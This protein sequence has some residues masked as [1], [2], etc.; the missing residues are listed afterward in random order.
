MA[1]GAGADAAIS[2]TPLSDP[3]PR[4]GSA[5]LVSFG[6]GG[7]WQA[8][9]GFRL[10]LAEP[11]AG[12]GDA[13]PHWDPANRLLT[14]F[15]PKGSLFTLPLTSFLEPDDLALMGQWQWLRQFIERI[16]VTSPRPEILQPGGLMDR[17]AHVLQRGVEGGHWMLT[18]PRLLTLVHAVQQPLGSP[19][20]IPLDVTHV[21][22]N[23]GPDPSQ[24]TPIAGRQDATELAPVTAWRRLGAGG[25]SDRRARAST[26]RPRR[27]STSLPP[28]RSRSTTSHSPARQ[29]RSGTSTSKRSSSIR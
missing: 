11:T 8:L 14:V 4:P 7:D 1:P 21:D 19:A 5:T 6:G 22:A 3:N 17:I 23:A 15:L 25:V 2:Y 13:S 20:F 12:T 9:V 28:G 10:A 26:A 24:T 27:R 29:P 18:P 16:T